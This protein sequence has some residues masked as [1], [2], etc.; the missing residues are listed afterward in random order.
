[1][2]SAAKG[3]AQGTHLGPHSML[4]WE[5]TDARTVA[6]QLDEGRRVLFE[7]LLHC[8]DSVLA[9]DTLQ[10]L[11]NDWQLNYLDERNPPLHMFECARVRA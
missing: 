1:M 3:R 2:K 10:Q 7:R 4:E 9:V 11:C 5:S 8:L 6:M